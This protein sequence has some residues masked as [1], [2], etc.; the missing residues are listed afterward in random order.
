MPTT[1]DTQSMDKALKIV[2]IALLL[3]YPALAVMIWFLPMFGDTPFWYKVILSVILVLYA[4]MRLY[5]FTRRP[6][7]TE[8]E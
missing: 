3:S 5:R 7:Y 2:R 6:R 8:E 1:L 4:G